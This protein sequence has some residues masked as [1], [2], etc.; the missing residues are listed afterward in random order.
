MKAQSREEKLTR[1]RERDRLKK[2]IS[3]RERA[4]KIQEEYEAKLRKLQENME[5]KQRD[6][7]QVYISKLSIQI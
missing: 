2:E 6:L 5:A 7:L 3:A 1:E 4:E